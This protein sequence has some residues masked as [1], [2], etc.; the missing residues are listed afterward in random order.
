MRQ[1][2]KIKSIRSARISKLSRSLPRF[3][4]TVLPKQMEMI[5]TWPIAAPSLR[6]LLIKRLMPHRKLLR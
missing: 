3:A 5:Y 4:I 2:S 1:V 6:H